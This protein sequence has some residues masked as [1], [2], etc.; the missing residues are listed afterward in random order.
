M[1]TL[2]QIRSIAYRTRATLLGDAAGA[3][4]LMSLFVVALYLPAFV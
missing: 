3:A 4:A 2:R 1:T